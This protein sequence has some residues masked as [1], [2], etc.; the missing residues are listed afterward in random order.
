MTYNL[1]ESALSGVGKAT[2]SV[3]S[4]VVAG[5]GEPFVS[6][7]RPDEIERVLRRHGYTNIE[8]FGS[9]EARSAY[10]SGRSDVIIASAQRLLSAKTGS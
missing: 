3:L 9:D 5:M 2:V 7:F 6:L 4:R 8:H 10:F 1:P